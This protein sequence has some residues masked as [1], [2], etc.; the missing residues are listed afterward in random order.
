[1]AHRD[2]RYDDRHPGT[3]LRARIAG[4]EVEVLDVSIGGMKLARDEETAYQIQNRISFELVSTHW[5]DMA[6]APGRAVVRAVG[7]DWVAVQFLSPTYN[8]MKCVSRHVGTL[9]WGH[10]PY[11][12]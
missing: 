8:L 11:G 5:P 12:Y 4:R 2:R 7:R 10:R 6:A 1:M 9:L 3:G